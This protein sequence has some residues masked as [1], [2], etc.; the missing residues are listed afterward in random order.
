MNQLLLTILLSFYSGWVQNRPSVLK[1]EIADAKTK[2]PVPYVNVTLRPS[3][4]RMISNAEGKLYLSIKAN[5]LQ[6]TLYFSCMGYESLAVTVTVLRRNNNLNQKIYLQESVVPLAEVR[7]TPLNARQIIERSIAHIPENYDNIH[8]QAEGFYRHA[9]KENGLFTTLLESV[10]K[11]YNTG[12]SAKKDL[13]VE[14]LKTRFSKDYRQFQPA[15]KPN[16][17]QNAL[18]HDHVRYGRGFLNLPNLAN[19][20]FKLTGYTQINQQEVYI[21]KASIPNAQNKDVHKASI[22]VRSDDYAILKIDYDY[23]WDTKNLT[24]E[25]FRTDSI[26]YKK[27]SWKG[28]FSYA[29]YRNKMVLNYF[30]FTLKQKIYAETYL[31]VSG[32]RMKNTKELASQELHEEFTVNNIQVLNKTKD[33]TTGTATNLYQNT[34]PYDPLFWQ[35]YPQPADSKLYQQV[36]ADMEKHAPLTAQFGQAGGN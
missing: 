12:Y 33:A 3:Q 5:L 21:I 35:N 20:Q 18:Q 26:K 32:G 17:L 9:V 13:G 22:F 6:D 15:K 28:T 4:L 31:T 29:P 23:N 11:V 36:K 7:V 14:Y 19:W 24:A 8:Y 16:L 1:L 34:Q 10:V 2:E 30:H 27:Y 25:P